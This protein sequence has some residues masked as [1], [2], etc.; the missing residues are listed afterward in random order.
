MKSVTKLFVYGSLRS[1]FRSAAYGYISR[2]FNF[3]GDAKVKGSLYDMGEYPAAVATVENNFV[4]GELYEIKDEEEFVWALAQLDDYE[5]LNVEIGEQA[6]YK[7]ELVTVYIN[8]KTEQGWIYWFAGPVEGKQI[9]ASGDM[10]EYL[11]QK[12]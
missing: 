9:I 1:G 2:Y 5:G 7:R 4:V 10:L 12:K 6:L 11:H 3:L 8:D